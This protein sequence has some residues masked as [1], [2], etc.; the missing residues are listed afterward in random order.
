MKTALMIGSTGLIGYH[1]LELL[2]HSNDY[3]KVITF[4]K[5]D[6][7][8]KH[9]KFTHHIVDFNKPETFK[10]SIIGDNLYCPI[11]TTIYTAGRNAA[12]RKDDF[13]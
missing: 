10:D 1:L 5:R 2:L 12:F 8:I 6:T 7:G 4:V 11:C 13:E 3:E 9:P